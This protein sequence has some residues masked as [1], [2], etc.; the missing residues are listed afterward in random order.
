MPSSHKSSTGR[1]RSAAPADG[2]PAARSTS[3]RSGDAFLAD[4]PALLAVE[5]AHPAGLTAAQI[6]EAF[7]SAGVHLSEATFRKWVQLGLLPRSRRV[8]RKGKHQ[9]SLG[10]Y[11][12]STV[13]QIAAIRRQLS[14]GLTIGDVARSRRLRDGLEALERGL[15]Q[16]FRDFSDQLQAESSLGERERRGAHKQVEQ[17]AEQARELCGRIGS[18]ERRIVEPLEREARARAFGSGTSGGAGDLL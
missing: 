14:A 13:R 6:V 15:S 17:L 11:P 10:L 12:P 18:L 4:E 16:L 7:T 9:G 5:S 3:R 1:T 2:S 8:G